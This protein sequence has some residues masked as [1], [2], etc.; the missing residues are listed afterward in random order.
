VPDALSMRHRWV[1]PF[2]LNGN[3]FLPPQ[4]LPSVICK[5]CARVAYVL[6]DIA[7]WF[8]QRGGA[9]SFATHRRDAPRSSDAVAVGTSS[10]EGSVG[11]QR[12]V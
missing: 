2:R 7:A 12:R 3:V 10:L 8:A 5:T 1:N 6:L 11:C 4:S 9:M